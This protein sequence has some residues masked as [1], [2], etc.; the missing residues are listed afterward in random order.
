MVKDEK[1]DARQIIVVALLSRL[2]LLLVYV[3]NK[4]KEVAGA[5]Q[6]VSMLLGILISIIAAI[7]AYLL[8]KKFRGFDL[9]DVAAVVAPKWSKPIAILFYIICVAITAST[10]SQFEFFMT[11]AIYP[12]ANHMYILLIFSAATLYMMYMGLEAISRSSLVIIILIVVSGVLVAFGVGD[13]IQL[14]NFRTPF[15]EDV[16]VWIEMAF[17]FFLQNMELILFSM[18]IPYMKKPK[19]GRAFL[20]YTFFVLVML[21]SINFLVGSVLGNYAKT[22]TFAIY[23]LF[24]ISGSEVFYRLDY[25]HVAGWVAMSLVRAS[26]YMILASRMLQKV[27]PNAKG[28]HIINIALATGIAI[29]ASNKLEWFQIL[30]QMINGGGPVLVLVLGVPILLLISYHTKKNDTRV[31]TAIRYCQGQSPEESKEDTG[32]GGESCAE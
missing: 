22:R 2:F 11:T 32:K 25:F 21:E 9:T 3:P 10:I 26:V 31:Q 28:C 5:V 19:I 13:K 17:R 30:F 27:F 8:L 7:P 20:T 6:A 16:S 12:R 24:S 4:G 29:V 23:T 15:V 1:I 14:L 18:L